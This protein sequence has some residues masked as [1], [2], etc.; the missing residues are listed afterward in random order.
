MIP[1]LSDEEACKLA[2]KHR[3]YV[4]GWMLNGQL[5]GGAKYGAVRH[6]SIYTQAGVPVGVTVVTN[7]NDIQVFVRK[8]HRRKG[9]GS[10]LVAHAMKC[11]GDR[12]AGIDA[13]TGLQNGSR[14]FWKANNVP[15]YD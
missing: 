9:I 5:R 10:K 2:L 14:Q 15:M 6:A 4:S 8:S 12:A 3:L 1:K 13:G 11:M 7:A